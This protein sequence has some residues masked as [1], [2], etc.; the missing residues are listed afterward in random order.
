[1]ASSLS[2]VIVNW[3][4]GALLS[5]C[6]HSIA[7]AELNGYPLRE[8]VIVDNAS[9]DGSCDNLPVDK[10]LPMR[11]VRN[12]SNQ[13]FAAA[14]NQGAKEA[15]GDLILFLN[16]DTCLFFNSLRNPMDFMTDVAN[17][18]VG[19]CGIRLVDERGTDTI[20]FAKFPT[21]PAFM[22]SALG[23]GIAKAGIGQARSAT[24][25]QV[26]IVDQVIGAFFLV[27]AEVFAQL[28]G[29]DERFFV[30]YEE[31][32]LSLRARQAGWSSVCLTGVS[33]QHVGGGATQQ[34]K[35]KRLF[36][37]LRS[38]L[39]FVK[40]HFSV[41]GIVAVLVVTFI[42]EPLARLLLALGTRSWQNMTD[43]V[44]AYRLLVRWLPRWIFWGE[45][46]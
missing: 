15:T 17:A 9:T 6:C 4:T 39:L 40:K 30:Y 1:M 2:I 29:F 42:I 10:A 11:I 5:E 26:L 46:R 28:D 21:P 35:A 18:Q 43:T 8:I 23:L 34:I 27:R 12:A 31:V 20:S 36:Y 16:P 33:A 41:M 19:V 22:R 45:T 24:R 38:R 32:D 7:R 44:G 37:L 3:N 14:C 25:N 13:G